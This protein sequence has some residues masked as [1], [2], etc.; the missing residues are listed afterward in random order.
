MSEWFSTSQDTMCPVAVLTKY[1]DQND[2]RAEPGSNA[3]ASL[4]EKIM[5]DIKE[6][7]LI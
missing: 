6:A 4:Y 7:L 5:V 2:A 3:P 1:P